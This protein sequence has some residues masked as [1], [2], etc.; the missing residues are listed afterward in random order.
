MRTP[1][2]TTFE[3]RDPYKILGVAA[4][5]PAAAVR[6]AYLEL[7][8]RHHPNLFATD[9]EKYRSSTV[10]MQDINAAYE[11]LS[12]PARREL[13]DRSRPGAPR[14]TQRPR[15]A[16]AQG[17]YYHTEHVDNIIRKYN[18]FVDSLAT[19][20]Q[21]EDAIRKIRAFQKGPAGAGYVKK[22]VAAIY[23]D[24]V[25]LL[26]QGRRISVYDD[27]L[28]ELMFLYEGA[29]EVAPSAVFTTYA[30]VMHRDN[31]GKV[32]A[33]LGPKPHRQGPAKPPLLQLR[34]ETGPAKPK[35]TADRVWEWLMAKPGAKP[36]Q[37]RRPRA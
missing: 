32:P 17:V 16:P 36:D 5:A 3:N 11:L 9:P 27:G 37:P 8:R 24:V 21:R 22:L 4:D 13:W 35:G 34:H 1:L 10:L 15:P 26:L 25:D 19:P 30:Y 6:K 14:K 29:L 18:E 31:H 33:D 7:A 2:D 20:A 12:D 28:V 23:G